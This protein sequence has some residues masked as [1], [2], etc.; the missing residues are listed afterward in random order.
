MTDNNPPSVLEKATVFLRGA[1]LTR[2]ITTKVGKGKNTIVFDGLPDSVDIASLNASVISGGDLVRVSGNFDNLKQSKES[3]RIKELREKL[4]K[5]EEDVSGLS[6]RIEV[7][8]SEEEFLK[9]NRSI[10]GESGI[11]LEDLKILNA[12]QKERL[13]EILTQRF[14]AQR[15]IVKAKEVRDSIAAELNGIEQNKISLSV[16]VE[17]ASEKEG[18]AEIVLSYFLDNAYWVPRHEFRVSESDGNVRLIAKGDIVQTTGE[19]WEDILVILSSGNPSVGGTQ[20]V[21]RPWFIDIIQP[22]PAVLRGT[23]KAIGPPAPEYSDIE[24]DIHYSEGSAS[25]ES[26]YANAKEGS[27][28]IDFELPAKITVPSRDDPFA[29]EIAAHEL[30]A[31]LQYYSV[32]KLD[33][34]VYLLAKIQE[35]ESLNLIEGEVSIFQGNTF[36]GKTYLEPGR[37]EGALELSLGRDKGIIVKRERGKDV[38]SSA[39]FGKTNKAVRVWNITIQ[40]TRKRDIELRL[41]DQ[42]PVSVNKSVVVDV[43]NL[44]GAELNKE[45]GE[46]SWVLNIKAGETVKKVLSYSVTYPKEGVVPLE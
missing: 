31:E 43:V 34:D 37:T 35:W 6:V 24:E 2:R 21:L 5:A 1:E 20:P 39:I 4:E 40:N 23:V 7:L 19:D 12:Y 33:R 14:R 9:L 32:S 10:A 42:I 41:L 17:I 16:S 11:K 15:E 13:D 27:T 3:G 45:T 29:V 44:S 30:K 22:H 25:V 26:N 18:T 8:R 46:V 38:A 36:V 28:S